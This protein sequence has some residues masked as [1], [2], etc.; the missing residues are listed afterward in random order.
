[1]KLRAETVYNRNS[2]GLLIKTTGEDLSSACKDG[3]RAIVEA[4]N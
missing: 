3:K 2:L 1:M 4:P